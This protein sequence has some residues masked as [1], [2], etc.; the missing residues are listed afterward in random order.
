MHVEPGEDKVTF[1][2][3]VATWVLARTVAAGEHSAS[4]SLAKSKI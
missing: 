1:A 2:N 4:D 3:D